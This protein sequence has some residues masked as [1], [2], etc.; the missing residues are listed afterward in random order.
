MKGTKIN[1][2]S[3]K[4]VKK[5]LKN[6][7]TELKKNYPKSLV[8]MM[9]AMSLLT[10]SNIFANTKLLNPE[11]TFSYY[12]L[13]ILATLFVITH[14]YL[15][16]DFLAKFKTKNFLNVIVMIIAVPAHQ[17]LIISYILEEKDPEKKYLWGFVNDCYS[18]AI[19]II[20]CTYIANRI[21][22]FRLLFTFFCVGYVVFRKNYIREIQM[23]QVFISILTLISVLGFL[24]MFKPDMFFSQTGSSQADSDS[25]L[26]SNHKDF[27]GDKNKSITI[28]K[29]TE[30]YAAP[31]TL[32]K[33]VSY[34]DNNRNKR[35]HPSLVATDMSGMNHPE[36][37]SCSP[38]SI[39][40]YNTGQNHLDSE[41]PFSADDSTLAIAEPEF[42][43]DYCFVMG[44]NQ[45]RFSKEIKHTYTKK[46]IKLCKFLKKKI[47][48]KD[49]IKI[50]SSSGK[51][52]HRNTYHDEDD[53]THKEG[54][55]WSFDVDATPRLGPK[56]K[57]KLYLKYKSQ[58]SSL[59]EVLND[60]RKE[61]GESDDP[62]DSLPATSFKELKNG[63]DSHLNKEINNCPSIKDH[64]MTSKNE[65]ESCIIQKDMNTITTPRNMRRLSKTDYS[66][67]YE[68]KLTISIEYDPKTEGSL[69]ENKKG[70]NEEDEG[71]ITCL[72]D[73]RIQPAIKLESSSSIKGSPLEKKWYLNIFV[74]YKN[75]V[76]QAS[77]STDLLNYISH[78]MRAP[79]VAVLGCMNHFLSKASNESFSK[80]K[81]FENLVNI[82][83]KQAELH[84]KN[85]LEACQLILE[86]S[87][88]G[89]EEIKG[90][91]FNLKKLIKDTIRI[92]DFDLSK[93][94]NKKLVVN[95]FGD[96]KEH[97]PSGV[98]TDKPSHKKNTNFFTGLFKPHAVGFI[99]SD[100]IR[101]KQIIINL[102][103]NALKYTPKGTVTLKVEEMSE[104]HPFLKL[105]PGIN[106]MKQI[107]ISIIDS[108][109]GIEE[110]NLNNLFKAFGRVQNKEDQMLNSK[111]VGLGLLLSNKMC[112]QISKLN[113]PKGIEVKSKYGEGA[114]FS[115]FVDNLF[116]NEYEMQLMNGSIKD[117]HAQKRIYCN[118][119]KDNI[120]AR[121]KNNLMNL[122]AEIVL[123]KTFLKSTSIMLV[124]DSELNLELI[125][126]MIENLGSKVFTFA[127][128]LDALDNL[129]STV[130]KKPPVSAE[131][132]P[133]ITSPPKKNEPCKSPYNIYI[134]DYEMPILNGG[135][136][137]KKVRNLGGEFATVP[138]LVASANHMDME[139]VLEK[140]FTDQISKPVSM[141]ELMAMLKK[142][143]SLNSEVFTPLV[144]QQMVGD[145]SPNPSANKSDGTVKKHTL[146]EDSV[147]RENPIAGSKKDSIDE[148]QSSRQ[149]PEDYCFTSQPSKLSYNKSS[150][151]P[152]HMA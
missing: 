118:I 97:D 69:N 95:F 62:F 71:P 147:K 146:I 119:D 138:I 66:K 114:T 148:G 116:Q 46:H 10:L 63:P 128:P 7:P 85:L 44:L 106:K 17:E 56:N 149:T 77:K 45:K 109:I 40:L 100:P 145:G 1:D 37:L 130:Q 48:S 70:S 15:M 108:G 11:S 4:I 121:S 42:E 142:Y 76:Q 55:K 135:E 113:R 140:G 52:I 127:N 93:N 90:T 111:G 9:L 38:K 72:F 82:Y 110:K 41:G 21:K 16:L 126:D 98:L 79:V 112:K 137:A 39:Q 59:E 92:F 122:Q 105:L 61:L 30:Q 60:L 102:I 20:Y 96:I 6:T 51:P 136:L 134:F 107:K 152:A 53:E 101:I 47:E 14:L 104:Q 64:E 150:S 81:A 78:E 43:F 5:G 94:K 57:K 91:E 133:Q 34:Y 88:S 8:M 19:P 74:L 67:N 129:K 18:L 117:E 143:L 31:T 132:T 49:E 3:S 83:L 24:W 58:H 2:K 131:A 28:Y 89:D 54:T 73:V 27:E 25:D 99:R 23:T 26:D 33:K 87:R 35:K 36:L 120:G 124:D 151:I 65:N 115:F 103:S 13:V 75:T 68:F 12:F 80:E 144:K 125:K 84:I 139:E 123:M 22:R 32:K 86:M 29:A 50:V 141:N